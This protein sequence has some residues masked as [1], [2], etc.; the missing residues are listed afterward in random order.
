V[1][2]V[3]HL[4]LQGPFTHDPIPHP[5]AVIEAQSVFVISSFQ[6]IPPARVDSLLLQIR[7]RQVRQI[8]DN[9][10]QPAELFVRLSG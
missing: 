7:N 10:R 4:D 9:S 5:I 2:N 8:L 6:G 3:K 1:A